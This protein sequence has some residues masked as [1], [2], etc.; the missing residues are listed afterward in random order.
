V[1]W[2]VA[3]VIAHQRLAELRASVA[4]C[5]LAPAEGSG[6]RRGAALGPALIR[7]G[8]W[9]LGGLGAVRAVAWKRLG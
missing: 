4:R 3:E 5:R 9:L 7:V 2:Y 1:N 6:R 8:H